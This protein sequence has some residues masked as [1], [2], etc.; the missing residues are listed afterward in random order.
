MQILISEPIFLF[1][2]SRSHA[3]WQR[4]P[5]HS[6]SSSR[7]DPDS[8][9]VIRGVSLLWLWKGNY[10]TQANLCNYQSHLPGWQMSHG[11]QILV[12]LNTA[13]RTPLG[14]SLLPLTS[15][16]LCRVSSAQGNH[17]THKRHVASE[18]LTRHCK[19]VP[20]QKGGQ[21]Q[22]STQISKSDLL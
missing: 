18:R 5:I 16:V 20:Q 1:E 2:S 9:H 11:C 10:R 8:L 14:K 19:S 21:I 6:S 13:S 3:W 4:H 7:Y 12:K 15:A 17:S 22:I